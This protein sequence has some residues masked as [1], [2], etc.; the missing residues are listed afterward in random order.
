MNRQD[1]AIG[2]HCHWLQWVQAR[3]L[4]APRT[5]SFALREIKET[6]QKR[7]LTKARLSGVSECPL[8]RKHRSCQTCP[9]H[10]S[11][12]LWPCPTEVPGVRVVAMLVSKVPQGLLVFPMWSLDK[13]KV[14]QEAPM[15]SKTCRGF[16]KVEL[17][18]KI[19]PF[20]SESLHQYCLCHIK[21]LPPKTN[22]EG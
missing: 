10:S 7:W 14:K 13:S 12:C 20:D 8:D 1:Y 4:N 17:C 22:T 2:K 18:Y 6:V 3:A 16:R 21:Q 5:A 9:C 11:T 15:L 19:T